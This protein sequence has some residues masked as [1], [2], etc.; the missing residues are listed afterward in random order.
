MV[1]KVYDIY[2]TLHN[3]ELHNV[4]PYSSANVKVV[5]SKAVKWDGCVNAHEEARNSYQIVI[6]LL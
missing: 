5:K 3:E 6:G 1:L 2:T 4:L